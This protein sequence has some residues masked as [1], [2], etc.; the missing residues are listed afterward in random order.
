MTPVHDRDLVLLDGAM[1]TALASAGVAVEGPAWSSRAVLEAPHEVAA[2][3]R[4]YA[5]AG[6]VIHTANTFRATSGAL[7]AWR[8]AP[9]GTTVRDWV[10][11]AVRLARGAVPSD[12]LV[13]ASLSPVRDCY[14]RAPP[15]PGF[16]RIHEEQAARLAEA[17][18]DLILCETFADPEEALLALD[19][20][21]ATGLP[22]WVSFTTGPAGDLLDPDE[23]ALAARAAADR[24]AEVVLV[25]CAPAAR[26]EPILAPLAR[27]G[28]RFGVYANVGGESE[29]LGSMVDWAAGAPSAAVLAGRAERYAALTERWVTWGARVVGGCCGT[30]P[31]H[32][33]AM[34]VRLGCHNSRPRIH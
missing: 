23:L 3:H 17:G 2:L 9:A 20:G 28:V 24:G 7:A 10:A 14:V 8:D 32:I 29:G 27:S 26:L 1:G 4:A 6:A 19:A 12:H 11:R 25:N 5:A 13:A 34:S 21:R 18:A 31:T 30:T 16:L 22:V 15:E 33:R